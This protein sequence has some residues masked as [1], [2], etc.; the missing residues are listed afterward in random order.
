[1]VGTVVTPGASFN[2]GNSTD[3]CNNVVIQYNTALGA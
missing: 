3:V 1:M 2:V